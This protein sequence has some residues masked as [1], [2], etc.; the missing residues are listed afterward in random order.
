MV[1]YDNA[2][3]QLWRCISTVHV[4][5]YTAHVPCTCACTC[6][7]YIQVQYMY[8]HIY[9]YT[10]IHMSMYII[11]FRYASTSAARKGRLGLART[12]LWCARYAG[13]T[14]RAW[15]SS[16]PAPSAG[17]SGTL[18]SFQSHPGPG[19]SQ[20]TAP[21]STARRMITTGTCNVCV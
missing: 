2:H 14:G 17:T 19:P 13:T 9:M 5:M 11:T 1:A 3:L 15:W 6:Y 10:C 8:I 16:R 7:I 18:N 12:T 20:T 21:L 4:H